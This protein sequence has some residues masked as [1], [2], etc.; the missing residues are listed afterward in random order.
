MAF[1]NLGL[2][3]RL[4]FIICTMRWYP[5]L[6]PTCQSLVISMKSVMFCN[7]VSLRGRV[8]HDSRKQSTGSARYQQVTWHAATPL[9]GS[10]PLW[11]RLPCFAYIF[12]GVSHADVRLPRVAKKNVKLN[13]WRLKNAAL[14]KTESEM[15][16]ALLIISSGTTSGTRDVKDYLL[17]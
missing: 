13:F 11:I 10:L 15:Y 12:V 7:S 3:W 17:L 4:V 2:P 6:P 5:L 16:V 9:I 1:F 8:G 14:A